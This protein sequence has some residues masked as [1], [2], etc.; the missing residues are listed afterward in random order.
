MKLKVKGC[1][2]GQYV[3]EFLGA[4]EKEA[5]GDFGPAL[6]WKFLIVGGAMDG[7]TATRFTG[8]SPTAK[9]ACG[10]MLRAITGCELKAGSEVDLE[11]HVGKRFHLLV[12]DAPSGNG[13]RV[14]SAVPVNEGN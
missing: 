8:D 5:E 3:G 7:Q 1:P 2:T 12:E 6:I 9:N 10:K 14:A 11:K 4:E 13:T